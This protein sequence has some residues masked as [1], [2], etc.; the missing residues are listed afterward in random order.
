[1]GQPKSLSVLALG[2]GCF[3]LATAQQPTSLTHSSASAH[4]LVAPDNIKWQPMPREWA[5]GPPPPPGAKTPREVVVIWGDPTKEG[6]P[7]MFRM[8]SVGGATVA[9]PPHWHPTD[10]NITVLSGVFCVGTGDK[11]DENACRDMPT[12]S[13]MVMPKGMHHFAVAKNSVIQIHGIGPFK[14]NW[15]R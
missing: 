9:V 5:D 8:R 15:V 1:M 11:Y 3:G 6:A 10:E 12:G 4:I 14:I 13:Y 7:F 2:I